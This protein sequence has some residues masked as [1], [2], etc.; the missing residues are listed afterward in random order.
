MGNYEYEPIKKL[1]ENNKKSKY[2]YIRFSRY[3]F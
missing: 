2:Y 3:R 1:K